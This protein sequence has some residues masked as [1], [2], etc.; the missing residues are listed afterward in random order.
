MVSVREGQRYW[1]KDGITLNNLELAY[2][3]I[4]TKKFIRVT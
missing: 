4:K 1:Y 2:C 3:K